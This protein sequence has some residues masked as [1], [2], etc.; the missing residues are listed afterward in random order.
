VAQARW[1]SVTPAGTGE[2][3]PGKSKGE[4]GGRTTRLLDGA[5]GSEPKKRTK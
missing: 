5:N 2:T 4:K 1:E 3:R